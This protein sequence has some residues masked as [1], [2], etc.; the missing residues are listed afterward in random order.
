MQLLRAPALTASVVAIGNFDGVHQ[1]HQQ[2]IT[3]L[4]EV[5][6]DVKAP[7]VLL[8]FEPQPQEFFSTEKFPAR[9]MRFFEKWVAIKNFHVD[10]VY[11]IRFTRFFSELTAEDFVKKI[12]IEKLHAKK[13]VIGDDFIFGKKYG[14]DVEAISQKMHDGERISSTRIRNALK[15]ADFDTVFAL[16]GRP[17]CLSGKVAYG[18]Q[19]G[20]TLG[21]PTA[22]IYLR[23]KQVPLMGIFI[24]RVHGLSEQPLPGVASIGFRPT[25]DGKKIILEVHLFDFDQLIYGQRITVELIQKIRDEKRFDSTEALIAEIDRDAAIARAYFG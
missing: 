11:V 15:I 2:L 10:Y 9:L 12:L 25:F 21:Y 3:R 23:R 6:C 18:D 7:S 5:V 4:T 17:F 8:T 20:R 13:I 19:I 22:N 1:G 24:A 16:T 14:F